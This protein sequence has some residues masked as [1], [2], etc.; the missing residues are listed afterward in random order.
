M[1]RMWSRNEL[2]N[3]IEQTKKNVSTLVDKD[4]N[5]R[6]QDFDVEM[7]TISGIT[8]TYSKASLSGS[9]LLIV[10]A[11]V[12]EAGTAITAVKWGE[13]PLPK[14]IRDKITPT[15]SAYVGSF[16]GQIITS[17]S[18]AVNPIAVNVDKTD[19]GL[20]IDAGSNISADVN[21]KYFRI[22]VDLLIDFE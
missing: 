22:P 14:W 6:F 3:S 2:K 11:G 13:L 8:F 4:G 19:T 15:Y 9:H 7:E 1:K 21:N 5:N 16:N 17:G 12:L 18:Y 10:I 20:R